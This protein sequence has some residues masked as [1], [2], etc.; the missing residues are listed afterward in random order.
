MMWRIIPTLLLGFYIN[1]KIVKDADEEFILDTLFLGCL[2]FV[3]FTILIATITYDF[4]KF[5]AKKSSHEF[6]PS[7]LG[8]LFILSFFTTNYILKYRDKSPII[9][10]A[11]YQGDLSDAWF[12]FRENGTYKFTNSGLLGADYFRG[13]YTI[14]DSMITL[15]KDTIN[16]IIQSKTLAIRTKTDW[17]STTKYALYQID[18]Q[19][20]IV[21]PNF[22]FIVNEDHRKN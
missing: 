9:L 15:D 10:S 13:T 21:D 5:K 11:I 4:R 19:F 12:E 6:L 18:S 1:Y 3:F 17:D 20:N 22:I 16:N 8:V 2:L 14:K 7:I